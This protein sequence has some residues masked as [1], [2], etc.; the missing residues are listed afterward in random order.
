MGPGVAGHAGLLVLAGR[1]L[2][3]LDR[4]VA[5]VAGALPN[6]LVVIVGGSRD[7][8][9]AIAGELALAGLDLLERVVSGAPCLALF[10]VAGRLGARRAG[11]GRSRGPG[12][13]SGRGG[14]AGRPQR[15]WRV[16]GGARPVLGRCRGRRSRGRGGLRSRRHAAAVPCG[17][18]VRRPG[19]G[20]LAGW[21]ARGRSRPAGLGRRAAASSWAA[22]R[23]RS[24]R[25]SARP[26]GAVRWRA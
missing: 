15:R 19:R 20:P 3:T 4:R 17:P 6:W 2:R 9:L 16:L 14:W 13:A 25:G 26:A 5:A 24:R 1:P 8:S 21:P 10:G 22:G 12:R 23:A 18:R 11:R 7:I